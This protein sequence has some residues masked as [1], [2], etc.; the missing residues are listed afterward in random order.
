MSA[1]YLLPILFFLLA[2]SSWMLVAMMV[3]LMAVGSLLSD[4]VLM[5]AQI[6]NQRLLSLLLSMDYHI[7]LSSV[8]L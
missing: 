2:L 5:I 8:S 4:V 7:L 6:D 3:T 1:L